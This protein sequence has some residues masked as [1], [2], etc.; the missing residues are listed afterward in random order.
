MLQTMS[1]IVRGRVQGVYY[2]QSAKEKA[3][4]LN[5]TGVVKNLPNGEVYILATGTAD[6]VNALI[7][8]CWQG[9]RRAFVTDVDHQI[10]PLQ[11][12]DSFKIEK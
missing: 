8:W 9:P 3:L 1:I 12:F 5:I 7:E 4:E 2:R 10:Q 11:Q 6:Q